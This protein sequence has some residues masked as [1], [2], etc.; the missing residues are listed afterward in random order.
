MQLSRTEFDRRYDN[1]ALKIAFIGMSNIGKSYTASRLSKSH[2]FTLIEVDK[3]IWEMLGE[4]SMAD[5]ARWQG[6]PYSDGYSEREAKSIALETDATRKALREQG[7]N[8]LLDTT[9]SVIY[10]SDD[11]LDTLR[12][13][14]VIVHIAAESHDLDRLQSD[15]FALPKPLVWRGKFIRDEKLSPDDNIRQCYPDL[16][17]SRKS[18][19][20]ALADVTLTASFILDPENAMDDIFGAIR[21]SDG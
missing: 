16:L 19:Y 21:P 7:G 11:V 6:Q 9:G 4:Q 13:N 17:A 10:I 8:Q 5:F 2:D 12:Q 20:E 1:G 3:L 14:W 18:A 15:Y